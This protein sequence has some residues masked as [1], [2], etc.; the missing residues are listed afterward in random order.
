MD[1]LFKGIDAESGQV[2][3]AHFCLPWYGEDEDK[4]VRLMDTERHFQY[5][6]EKDTVNI[7]TGFRDKEGQQIFDQDI[8]YYEDVNKI[9]VVRFDEFSCKMCLIYCGDS[10]GELTE[11]LAHQKLKVVGNVHSYVR[12]DGYEANIKRS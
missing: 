1:Y 10:L 7:F 8:C 12:R 11:F 9:C 4:Y 6:V 5:K 3:K 2:V